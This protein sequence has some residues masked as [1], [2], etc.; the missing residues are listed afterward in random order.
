MSGIAPDS[1]DFVLSE[2][3]IVMA[4]K[5]GLKVVAEGVETAEQL[6][7]LSGINCDFVQGYFFSRPVPAGEFDKLL[8]AGKI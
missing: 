3:I 6:E 2:A 4:H 7:L 5:L 1:S 8:S